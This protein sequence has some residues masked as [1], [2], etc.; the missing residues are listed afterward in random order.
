MQRPAL[1]AGCPVVLDPV[2]PLRNSLRELAF[3]TL[4]QPQRV[5]L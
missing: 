2:A 5:S 4:R 1:Q 3:A